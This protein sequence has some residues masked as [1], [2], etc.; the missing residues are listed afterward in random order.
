MLAH[1]AAAVCYHVR[2][3]GD[4][5]HVLPCDVQAG[6]AAAAAEVTSKLEEAG[7]NPKR[8]SEWIAD[9]G[10]LH[11]VQ[12][13]SVVVPSCFR[14]SLHSHTVGLLQL[15]RPDSTHLCWPNVGRSNCL[16]VDTYMPRLLCVS[17]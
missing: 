4:A 7:K 15:Q 11:K 2:H 12:L 3:H 14:V 5:R 13:H 6:S 8:I 1:K 10:N 17:E 9:I 16:Y